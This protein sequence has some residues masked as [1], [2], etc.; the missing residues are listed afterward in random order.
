[1]KLFYKTKILINGMFPLKNYKIDGYV[2]KTGI[3]DDKM[4]DSEHP[5]YIFYSAGHLL[6]SCYQCVGKQGTFYEYF[7]SEDLAEYEVNDELSMY[8]I[9]KIFLEEQTQKID[10]LQEKI[11]LLTGLA[12]ALPVFL[13]T[14]YKDDAFYTYVGNITWTI[15]TLKV[16]DYDDHMKQTLK[17]RLCFRM[18][19]S[20]ITELKEKNPRYKRALNFYNNSFESSDIGVRFTLLFSSLE[21][22]FDITAENVT[23]EVSKYASKILFLNKKQSRSS[24]WK[25]KNYYDVRS[26][27]IH[28][29]DG[30]EITNKIEHNLRE[31]VR[32]ILLIY[33]SIS[34]S[35][36]ITD[37]Q[38][39][40]NLL[41]HID[42]DTIHVSVQIFVKYLRTDPDKFGLL[43]GKIRDNFLNGNYHVLSS[44]AYTI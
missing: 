17:N 1:M 44:E 38:E 40:K 34:I 31:Y 22:L 11:R 18:S 25:L 7:E 33:W 26:K 39:I 42:N 15:T 37:A 19:D 43:Y 28:G 23:T 5:D 14:I 12:I 24:K 41:D 13:I 6:N 21:A 16:P 27:Y 30:F 36:N 10:L 9:Q 3:V 35:Y 32:E 8:E 20:T 4:I 2:E 29:N